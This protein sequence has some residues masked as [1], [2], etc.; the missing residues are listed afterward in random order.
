MTVTIVGRTITVVL[1]PLVGWLADVKGV[2]FV[3][4]LG[5]CTLT[6]FGF[7]MFFVVH[8]IPNSFAVAIVALGAANGVVTCLVSTVMYAFAAELFPTAVR[9]VG[10]GISINVGV[11]VFGGLAPFIAESSLSVSQYGPGILLSA[12]G[13]LTAGMLIVGM[14]LQSQ[15]K[16]QMAHIRPVPYFGWSVQ[17]A[18]H[19]TTDGGT[20]YEL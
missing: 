7:P 5:A 17:T 11:G 16:M 2:G 12:A 13:A 6:V 8:A 10:C 19:H 3:M 20:P 14:L 4:M 18:H 1:A 15:G 9:T